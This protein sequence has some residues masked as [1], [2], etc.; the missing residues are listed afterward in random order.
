M[1]GNEF[2][3]TPEWAR[4]AWEEEKDILQMECNKGEVVKAK[5]ITQEKLIEEDTLESPPPSKPNTF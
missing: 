2:F 1:K 4:V 3:L 5:G